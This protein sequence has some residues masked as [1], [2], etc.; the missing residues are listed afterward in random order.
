MTSYVPAIANVQ[1]RNI[2]FILIIN[3]WN[4]SVTVPPSRNDLCLCEIFDV[5][6][7]FGLDFKLNLHCFI[8]ITIV[9]IDNQTTQQSV[10]MNYKSLNEESMESNNKNSLSVFFFLTSL[11]DY[12]T[13]SQRHTHLTHH[14]YWKNQSYDSKVYLCS[15]WISRRFDHCFMVSK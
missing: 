2:I 9:G 7:S 12:F 10:N 13:V 1:R 5:M 8:F 15:V 6:F 11:I 14:K 3:A 4:S